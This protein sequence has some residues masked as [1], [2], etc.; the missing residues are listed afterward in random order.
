MKK[1]LALFV[2]VALSVAVVVL[3][4][5]HGL[6]NNNG[7]G[8]LRRQVPE[9]R[10]ANQYIVVLKDDVSDVDAEALRLARDFGGDRNEGHTYHKAIKGFS[11]RMSEQ[12]AARLANDPRVDY[13]EE[14]GKVSIDRSE[15]HTS[16]LQSLRHLVCRLLLEKKKK[17]NNNK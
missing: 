6:N 16:E 11:V 7:Q 3:T 14:D 17:K 4:A 15:E 1:T 5:V 12:Q 9:K 8:K 10:I 2:L 13:V